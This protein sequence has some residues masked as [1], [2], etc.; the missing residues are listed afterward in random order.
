VCGVFAEWQPRYA[1]HGV[2]TFPVENKRP[3]VRRW[4]EVGLKASSKLAM[5]FADANA[6]GFQCGK[7]SRITLID[8]DSND[9]RMVNEAARL[10]GESPILWRTGSGNYAMPFRHN[11]EARRIRPMPGLPIDVL[12]GGYAVAPPSMGSEARYEFL[13]GSVADL[14]RLPIARVAKVEQPEG[15]GDTYERIR[16]GKRDDTLFRYALVHAPYV[17]DLDGLMDVVRT[18]NNMDCE[19]RL[20]DAEVARIA[21]SAWR[22]EQEGRNLVGR[23]RAFVISNADYMHLREQGGDAAALLYCELRCHHWGRDFVLANAMAAAMGWGL[24][25]WK[26]ARDTLVRLG[27]IRCRHR[28]GRGPHDPSIYTWAKGYNPAPQ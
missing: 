14:D 27:F 10:F 13:Q 16:E 6:F 1:E 8:I 4:Q 21:A 28:G 7:R 22:Y 17:D 15:R 3:C 24:P 20:P 26:K 11:G 23:G 9:P 18:R 25:K 19:P 5:K 12:G 2:A